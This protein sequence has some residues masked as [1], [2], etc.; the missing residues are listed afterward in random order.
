MVCEHGRETHWFKF[1]GRTDRA[2]AD[3]T[4]DGAVRR[5]GIVATDDAS[6]WR[7]HRRPL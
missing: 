1:D 6:N 5:G 4:A 3:A 2:R 7:I